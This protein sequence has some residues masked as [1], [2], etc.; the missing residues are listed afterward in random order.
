MSQR[1]THLW[2]L[3]DRVLNEKAKGLSNLEVASKLF[4]YESTVRIIVQQ[5]KLRLRSQV[6]AV[7][8]L[9]D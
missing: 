1:R 5:H 4:L 9:D 7:V 8:L 6:T 2:N 3:E